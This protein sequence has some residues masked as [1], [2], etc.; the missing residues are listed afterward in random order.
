MA[1]PIP[2]VVSSRRYT[3]IVLATALLT[4]F[5]AMVMNRIIDPFDIYRTG[6]I[7]GLN[8]Y[9]PEKYTRVRLLKA[10]E[11]W[12]LQPHAIVLGT[13]RSHI[14]IRMTHPGWFDAPPSRY[15][16]AFDGATTHE[17]Y[18]YLRHAAG[19]GHL[20][21][22][23]LGL[24]TWQ[25][26]M[27]PSGVRPDFNPALLDVPN[28][29]WHN[30]E[31]WLA[32]LRIAFSADT[33][34]ASIH[35]VSAQSQAT[36]DWLAPDGQRL[37]PTFFHHSTEY[38]AGP[39]NYFWE[40]DRE[41]I[42]FKL[43]MGPPEN[44]RPGAPKPEPD[45][46]SLEYV[47]RIIAF[48]HEHDIDLRIFITPAHAHQME[49]SAVAGEWPKIEAG[50][51][52]LVAMLA[53]DAAQHSRPRSFP[54]WDFSGYS[55]VTT[56]PVPPAD[57]HTEM[58]FYWDS[59]HFKQQVGDW[60]LDRLFGEVPASNPP[61]ADFGVQL[62]S[63]TIDAALADIRLGRT[64]YRL[65]HPN[66]EA[67]LRSVV[68]V[69]YRRI[70]APLFRARPDERPSFEPASGHRSPRPPERRSADG[71]VAICNGRSSANA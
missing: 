16:L 61:P 52:A 64:S 39:S 51:R 47:R 17:M 66:E 48:C 36:P 62:T 57:T 19:F 27:N 4:C 23:V 9:K 5:A 35:T 67:Q 25:L 26:G 33:V 69:V 43:D 21:Q 55:S 6:A 10:Y 3:W 15:N 68:A 60:V 49:I 31:T 30:I 56:E 65:S 13:S 37:G 54:L 11:V 58:R 41:E 32:G 14:G 50:K 29:A 44:P 42:G 45:L 2:A 20:A 46:P 22:V 18:A 7:V 38:E 40:V 12:H 34:L 53:D 1:A 59:S 8:I 70:G 24:D 63:A 71:L 28:S